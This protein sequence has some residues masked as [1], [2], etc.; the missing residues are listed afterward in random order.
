MTDGDFRP[1]GD[2]NGLP[3][4]WIRWF[5][6]ALVRRYT[7][8]DMPPVE[9]AVPIESGEYVP[10][11]ETPRRRIDIRSILVDGVVLVF[12]AYIVY[13]YTRKNYER[14]LPLAAEYGIA[15]LVV[16]YLR[17]LSAAEPP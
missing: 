9:G 4:D 16:H 1:A 10:A 7:R 11:P 12:T 3:P 8:V 15:V 2:D 13:R 17:K 6:H 14:L 5:W